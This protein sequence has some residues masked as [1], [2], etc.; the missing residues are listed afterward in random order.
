VCSDLTECDWE[1]MHPDFIGDGI[2]HENLAGCYNSA[3]CNWDGGDCCKDTCSPPQYSYAECGHDGYACRDPKS[4]NCDPDYQRDCMHGDDGS[5]PIPVADCKDGFSPYL[6]ELQDSFGDG[7]DTT[8]LMIVNKADAK[9]IVFEGKLEEGSFGVE[10]ICLDSTSCYSATATGG[11]WG[12]EVSWDVRGISTGS[13]SF[14]GVSYPRV[15]HRSSHSFAGW[16]T[17]DL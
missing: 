3:A 13:P 10:P 1:G 12:R 4:D 15:R 11:N 6:L 5:Q 2:C 9:E 16:I 8:K 17:D 14:A 7:W